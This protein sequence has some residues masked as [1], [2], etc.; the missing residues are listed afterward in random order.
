MD[1]GDFSCRQ[2]LEM[3]DFCSSIIQVSSE[4]GKLEVSFPTSG[5]KCLRLSKMM[6]FTISTY[7]Q[8][9]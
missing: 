7:R 6:K 5:S 8:S 2:I 1:G 3:N 9:P 4:L